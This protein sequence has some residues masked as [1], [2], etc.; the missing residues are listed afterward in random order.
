MGQLCS[1]SFASSVSATNQARAG[2][3]DTLSVFSTRGRERGGRDGGGGDS[4][5][6][7]VS[8]SHW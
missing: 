6:P 1:L 4:A 7:A 3:A 5:R 8:R 2:A